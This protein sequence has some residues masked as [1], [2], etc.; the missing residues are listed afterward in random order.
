MRRRSGTRNG[1]RRFDRPCGSRRCR[2]GRDLDELVDRLE[3][4]ARGATTY[5]RTGWRRQHLILPLFVKEID[6]TDQS[7]DNRQY[8][9]CSNVR[10]C[11][12][13]PV[14]L[15]PKGKAGLTRFVVREA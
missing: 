12:R 14:S 10:L 11:L 5:S 2:V 13:N 3:Q 7:K 9:Y 4:L 8:S 15:I 6:E 1:G